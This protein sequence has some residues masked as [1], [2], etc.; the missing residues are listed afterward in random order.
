MPTLKET[1]VMVVGQQPERLPERHPAGVVDLVGR[2]ERAGGR[3]HL[4]VA[5]G[6]GSP[7]GITVAAG[8]DLAAQPAPEPGLLLDLAQ[9][10]LGL[11]LARVELALGK[12]PVVIGRP[13]DQD[14]LDRTALVMA[15][16]DPAAGPDDRLTHE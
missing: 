1:P 3:G 5:D 8:P 4:P 7:L 6:L 12:R 16:D 10:R 2:S 13:V 11:G 14:D 15:P 9:R